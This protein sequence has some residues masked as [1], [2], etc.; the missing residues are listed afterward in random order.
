MF[1]VLVC[2]SWV[3]FVCILLILLFELTVFKSDARGAWSSAG[4]S[5]FMIWSLMLI[6][7][8]ISL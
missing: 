4:Q 6:M 1:L 3:S 2:V 7:M 5:N 8:S